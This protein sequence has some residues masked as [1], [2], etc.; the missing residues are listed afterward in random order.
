MRTTFISALLPFVSENHSSWLCEV[1][2]QI[3]VLVTQPEE[4]SSTSGTYILEREDEL[5][6]VVL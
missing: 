5:L 4:L 2:Q 6:V 3:K 1:A